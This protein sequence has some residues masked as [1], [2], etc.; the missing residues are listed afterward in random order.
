MVALPSLPEM[1]SRTA[2]VALLSTDTLAS[3]NIA[4][5]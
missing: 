4:P 3:F 1:A 5:V 2:P